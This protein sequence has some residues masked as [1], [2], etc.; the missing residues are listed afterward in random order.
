MSEKNG[1]GEQQWTKGAVAAAL[2]QKQHQQQQIQ[3]GVLSSYNDNAGAVDLGLTAP[4]NSLFGSGGLIGSGSNHQHGAVPFSSA[5]FQ[6][7]PLDH[8]AA[9]VATAASQVVSQGSTSNMS[10]PSGFVPPPFSP[11][12]VATTSVLTP[13]PFAVASLTGQNTMLPG[14][15]HPHNVAPTADQQFPTG[16][17]HPTPTLSPHQLHGYFG[18]DQIQHLNAQQHYEL[19]KLMAV[20]FGTN[21][22]HSSVPTNLTSTAGANLSTAAA[23]ASN[24]QLGPQPSTSVRQQAHT[25]SS[26]AA[27]VAAAEDG[28]NASGS[29]SINSQVAEQVIGTIRTGTSATK[30]AITP[31]H[32]RL[33]GLGIHT[34]DDEKLKRIQQ[35]VESGI[36]YV[37]K[38][39]VLFVCV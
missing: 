18:M 7:P 19:S 34:P 15:N 39:Y 25:Q 8:H 32:G 21:Q 9:S 20:S 24:V 30:L 28:S 38:Q 35:L 2:S 10:A 37:P 4:V 14:T 17:S 33:M 16:L 12:S 6:A 36:R 26:S 29:G 13:N 11:S 1:Q 31:I 3:Q 27:T 5:R 23:G 22:M